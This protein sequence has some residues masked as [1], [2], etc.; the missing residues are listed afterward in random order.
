MDNLD[1]RRWSRREMLRGAALVLGSIPGS[2]I[3]A[4]CSS[5]AP[6]APAAAPTQ[7]APAAP[8]AA[9]VLIRDYDPKKGKW[10]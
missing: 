6:P 10:L 9:N 7:P 1:R 8:M 3:L 5:G 4:A 2:A